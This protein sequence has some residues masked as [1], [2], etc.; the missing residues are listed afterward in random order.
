MQKL[1]REGLDR[2]FDWILSYNGKIINYHGKCKWMTNTV[3]VV[4]NDDRGGIDNG[5]KPFSNKTTSVVDCGRK[6][7][8]S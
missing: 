7:V 6:E 8:F 2:S 5:T 3:V 4:I 1:V